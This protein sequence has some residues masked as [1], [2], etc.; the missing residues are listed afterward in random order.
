MNDETENF[1][2]EYVR[3]RY[4]FLMKET[5]QTRSCLSAIVRTTYILQ[6]IGSVL[7]LAM[8]ALPSVE[9]LIH[10]YK[11][12]LMGIAALNSLIGG[13]NAVM[14]Q[15]ERRKRSKIEHNTKALSKIIDVLDDGTITKSEL[16]TI[17]ELEAT[18]QK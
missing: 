12:I 6:G 13:I 18:E 10:D 5:D 1:K 17:I 15:L 14:L 16:E 8:T 9:S 7:G 3:K 2:V 11:Y 4:D